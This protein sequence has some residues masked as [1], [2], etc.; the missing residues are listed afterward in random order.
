[1]F[2]Q[3]R[4]LQFRLVQ[5]GFGLFRKH[6]QAFAKQGLKI[7]NADHGAHIPQ[8]GNGVVER[9]Q[10]A[11]GIDATADMQQQDGFVRRQSLAT[12]FRSAPSMGAY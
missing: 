7:G 3:L 12:G 5:N 6:F 4:R 2:R 8:I 11:A 1:M 10:W 9:L